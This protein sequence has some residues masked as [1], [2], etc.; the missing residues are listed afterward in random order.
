MKLA[1]FSVSF[2][3]SVVLG[4]AVLA[5]AHEGHDKAPGEDSEGSPNGPIAITAEAKTNLGLVVE[6]AQIRTLDKTLMVIGQIEAIPNRSAAVSSRISGRVL[7]VKVSDGEPVKKGQLLVDVESRQA[8]D[9]PPRVQYAA[10]ID[11]I[12]TD[13]D[14]VT[15]D[16]VEPDKHLLEIVNLDEVYA[17]GRIYEGQV[18]LIKTG[19]Q[20]RVVVESYPNN[21]F[22]GVL[23]LISG[24][25][26]AE[27]RTL[28]AWVRIKN[29]DGKLRPNMRATLHI[30]TAEAD[31][32]V[33]IPI[34]AILGDSG[35]LF[36]FVQSD[37]DEL[38]FERRA[39]VTGIKDDRYVE[40]V[41]GIFPSD[42]VVTVGNYQLQ[43]VT[44]KKPQAKPDGAASQA[45]E[46]K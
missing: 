42:K 9:P 29:P 13:R 43:Y 24:A 18:P 44:T 22:P 30:V 15:G 40:I 2:M 11:G 8:G 28:R 19:Q 1:I 34:S 38:V 20:V 4:T 31:S 16:S 33:A 17:E 6:E 39:V 14:V 35:N 5:F 26:D 3:T 7:E 41:E 25:L 27:T 10:P 21:T 36:A 46:H 32:A 37:S 23:E 45:S 12:V